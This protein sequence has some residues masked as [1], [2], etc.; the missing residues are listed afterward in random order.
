MKL[1]VETIGFVPKGVII[2]IILVTVSCSGQKIRRIELLGCE[3]INMQSHSIIVLET[4][5]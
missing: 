2:V 3:P 4:A 1:D 5:K